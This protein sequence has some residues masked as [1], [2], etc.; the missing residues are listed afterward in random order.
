M[1]QLGA[2]TLNNANGLALQADL[3]IGGT[4]TLTTGR[5]DA[6]FNT[7]VIGAGASVARAGGWVVGHLEKHAATGSGVGLTFEVGDAGAYTP[8]GVTFATVTGAGELTAS[9]TAGD[10]PDI[11]N[12]G[13]AVS[14]DVNRYWTVTNAGVVFDTYSATFT[15]VAGDI[16]PGADTS[17]FI[18]AKR[19]GTTWTR[20]AVGTRTAFEHAGDRHDLVQRLRSRPAHG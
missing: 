13:L 12:S 17:V 8:I 2:L 4:L 5:L 9:T 3:T 11:A 20:P 18:V 14:R 19:D 1:A 15:F 10:H 16:D 6:G 7:V